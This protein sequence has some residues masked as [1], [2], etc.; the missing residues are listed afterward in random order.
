MNTQRWGDSSGV[1]KNIYTEVAITRPLRD[2]RPHSA[3]TIASS[4]SRITRPG[5][6][7]PLESGRFGMICWL[8]HGCLTALFRLIERY[9]IVRQLSAGASRD[10]SRSSELFMRREFELRKCMSNG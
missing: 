5:P 2:S 7:S 10:N 6:V 4:T 3:S 1:I 8:T 9:S